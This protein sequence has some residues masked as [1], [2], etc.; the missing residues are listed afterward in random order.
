MKLADNFNTTKYI[1]SLKLNTHVQHHILVWC[2]KNHNF[3][4][5]FKKIFAKLDRKLSTFPFSIT[6]ALT[7]FYNHV[8]S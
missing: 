7:M 8:A 1:K 5:H 3:V 6:S 4:L 2:T